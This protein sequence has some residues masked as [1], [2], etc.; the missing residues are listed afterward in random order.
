MKHLI[1]KSFVASQVLLF[2]AADAF[3]Q[4][5]TN[6][7][8]I[9]ILADD[10]GYGDVGYLGQ[11]KFPTPNI[12]KLVSK[13]VVFTQHY[14]GST[15]C[16][17]SR[18]AL[19]TG[20][21]TG[22]TPIRGNAEV[23]PEGQKPIPSS[24]FTMG[25]LFQKHG[26]YTGVFGKWGLGYPG[27]EGV[28]SK[29]GFD[30]FYGYNCQRMAHNYFPEYLWENN[31]KVEL[32]GNLNNQTNDYAV[33]LIH[34]KA[35]DFI[36]EHKN[37][38]FFMYYATPLPHAELFMP[39]KYIDPFKGK[40]LPEK[41]YKGV[42][43]GPMLK[44]GGYRSQNNCH[45]TFAAMVTL[46]DKQVGDIMAEVKRQGLEKNTII[47]FTSDNGPH[48]EGGADPRYFDSNGPFKGFK[49]DLYEGGIHVPMAIVWEG[50][51]AKGSSSDHLS[52]FW[53]YMPTFAELLDDDTDISYD[54]VSMLPSIL[55][56]GRQKNHDLL[57][58]EF[59][60]VNG[61]IA[62]RKGKWKLVI[63]DV[64]KA[65]DSKIFL[66]NL[67]SDPYEKTDL[68]ASHPSIVKR[69]LKEVKASHTNS[70][71]FPMNSIYF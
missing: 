2:G 28:P 35:I 46:L 53:D 15:V 63:Y 30:Y 27:S 42:D 57:Y 54:G 25:E 47:V 41:K 4:E 32:K 52:A 60:G 20:F 48:M 7:N 17:P 3:S 51:I 40:Y 37:E 43:S 56:K 49:R 39:E 64:T 38:P 65:K 6:P 29:Q 14:S 62:C 68:A 34:D 11:S 10:L 18:S 26:Y 22:H 12:D 50:K 59:H 31:H 5:S 66:Y 1:L 45:A 24:S 69:M 58:W 9:F 21:H 55:D 44:Q 71:L 36:R 23:R 8:V 67:K 33:D 13:G 16:A 70:K 19:L 61:R